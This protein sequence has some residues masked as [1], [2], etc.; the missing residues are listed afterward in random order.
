MLS[1]G[2]VFIAIPVF[3][4]SG[5]SSV[6]IIKRRILLC[7]LEPSLEGTLHSRHQSNTSPRPSEKLIFSIVQNAAGKFSGPRQP[8]RSMYEAV[9]II[10]DLQFSLRKAR[11]PPT[12]GPLDVVPPFFNNLVQAI[13]S[14]DA[15]QLERL[16]QFR[17]LKTSAPEL[18]RFVN[19]I[20]L[21]WH[22]LI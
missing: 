19:T 13:R 5:T 21:V 10:S 8:D 12:S 18:L 16:F 6:T 14:R 20:K 9:E 15:S 7:H 22:R 1:G 17:I 3:Y 4:I 2:G 11:M